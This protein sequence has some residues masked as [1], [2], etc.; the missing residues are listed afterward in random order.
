M[1]LPAR[2]PLLG[3]DRRQRQGKARQHVLAVDLRLAP[4]FTRLRTALT[5]VGLC[6]LWSVALLAADPTLGPG[7]HTRSLTVDG[8]QRSYLVHVPA[9]CDGKAPA[10]VVLVYHG[11]AMNGPMMSVFC[12][13]NKKADEAGFIAVYPNGTGKWGLFLTWNVAWKGGAAKADDVA[14]TRRLLDDLTHVL[15]V[16]PKRIFAT[17]LSNG[18]MM[19]Y[20]LAAEL[21][22]RIAAIAPVAGA[23]ADEAPRPKRPVSLLHCH[24]TDDSVVPFQGLGGRGASLIR[25]KSVEDSIRAWVQLDGCPAQPKV[26]ELACPIDDGTTVERKTYGP[27]TKG[28]E[29]VLVLIRGGGHTWPG[30]TPPVGFLGKSTKNISAN[31]LLWEF[32]QRHPMP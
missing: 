14:F 4:L 9:K 18:G 15:H 13:L 1:G 6:L 23:M 19:C 24:G 25:F 8:R 22:D 2:R 27:G 30:Q 29:V 3:E 21:S 12:G 7:D 26:D 28:A 31:D 17:G 16:D 10:P 20:R 32:F 11:A 5:S